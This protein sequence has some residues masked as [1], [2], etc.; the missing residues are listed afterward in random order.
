MKKLIIFGTLVGIS[1]SMNVAQACPNIT[2]HYTCAATSS[3][4]SPTF[5]LNL[6]TSPKGVVSVVSENTQF[7]L[8]GTGQ[9]N[10]DLS[11]DEVGRLINKSSISTCEGNSISLK[12]KTVVGQGNSSSSEEIQISF[13]K[14]SEDKIVWVGH[15]KT[16]N[17]GVVETIKVPASVCKK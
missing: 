10:L 9:L 15:S 2:G 5:I 1:V 14:L 11:R 16:I 13:T 17:G 12:S 3:E 4:L 7:E 6:S 8:D